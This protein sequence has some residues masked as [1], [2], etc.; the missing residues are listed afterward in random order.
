[1]W[2]VLPPAALRGGQGQSALAEVLRNP[3]DTAVALQLS[4]QDC[5]PDLLLLSGSES[6]RT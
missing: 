2:W 5:V 4:L 1:M 6:L 3:G